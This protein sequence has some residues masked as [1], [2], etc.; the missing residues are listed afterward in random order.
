MVFIRAGW[1][2]AIAFQV[3]WWSFVPDEVINAMVLKEV[4]TYQVAFDRLQLPDLIYPT[5]RS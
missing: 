3:C 5:R 2:L 4:S 1:C